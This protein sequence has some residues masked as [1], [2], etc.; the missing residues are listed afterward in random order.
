MMT[1]HSDRLRILFSPRRA[2]NGTRAAGL[3]HALARAVAAQ[4]ERNMAAVAE[5]L[6]LT[7]TDLPLP[8]AHKIASLLPADARA[9]A[10]CV[11]SGWGAVLSERSLWTR[12]N[13]SPSSGVRVRVT[14][15][16]LASAAEKARGQLAALD[17][18]GCEH[19]TFDALLGVVQANAGALRELCVGANTYDWPQ[20]L[21]GFSS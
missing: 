19:L 9:C 10:A 8:L 4:R 15:A 2:P 11:C 12:L 7:L 16:V 18:C 1:C 21:N 20:T 13:L 17:F 3:L 5:E 6:A 14:D